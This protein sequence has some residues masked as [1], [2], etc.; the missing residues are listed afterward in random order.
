MDSATAAAFNAQHRGPLSAPLYQARFGAPSPF[1]PQPLPVNGIVTNPSSPHLSSATPESR[2]FSRRTSVGQTSTGGSLRAQSQPARG[3][4]SSISMSHLQP[5]PEMPDYSSS[6][7]SSA[8]VTTHESGPT[9]SSQRSQ[10]GSSLYD[11]GRKPA[12]YV[13]YFVGQS[14]YLQSTNISPMSSHTGLAIHNGGLS[15]RVMS[16]SPHLSSNGTRTTSPVKEAEARAP[17]QESNGT[18]T[19][20]PHSKTEEIPSPARRQVPLIVDG[21]VNSPLRRRANG[22][23]HDDVEEQ[24]TF[25]ASTSEDLAFDTPSSSDD[26]EDTPSKQPE[27]AL[28]PAIEGF[29][30]ASPV[31]NGHLRKQTDLNSHPPSCQDSPSRAG[32]SYPGHKMAPT[33]WALPRQLSAVQE[34]RT[35]SPGFELS[36]PMTSPFAAAAPKE[37]KSSPLATRDSGNAMAARPN[38]VPQPISNG[39]T[40]QTTGN[41]KKHRKKKTTKSENDAG[42]TNAAGGDVLPLD[43]TQRKGG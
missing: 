38:G 8:S 5:A 27:K 11:S 40:W 12:E 20:N 41:R 33:A 43:D 39:S 4:V 2:R 24:N 16:R 36:P 6:R 42:T 21:S 26:A 13:G 9:Y 34:V 32:M 22:T 14:P 18:N 30:Q 1:L 7:R 15:P 28:T 29:H 35:P 10:H 19:S 25:S 17:A 31:M 37:G 3:L 23:N